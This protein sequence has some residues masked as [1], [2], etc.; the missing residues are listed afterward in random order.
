MKFKKSYLGLIIIILFIAGYFYTISLDGDIKPI[1][2]IGFVKF[3]NPD[4]YP[5]NPHSVDVAR[6]A[7][8]RNSKTVLVVHYGGSSNYSTY[9]EGNITIIQ[10]G[11]ISPK[12][13][14]TNIDWMEVFRFAFWGVPDGEWKFKANGKQFETLDEALIYIQGIAEKKGQEGSIPM[15]YHGTARGG[16]TLLSQGCGFPLYYY[17]SWK[18]Y[19][20]IAAYYYVLQGMIFPFF[21][22]PT[23]KY[24]LEHASELE[25]KYRN[26]QLDMSQKD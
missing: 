1:G 19:G 24:E 10:L 25:E 13:A 22:L 17:I 14:T 23:W 9:K 11:F 12:G 26:G 8:E 7:E 6:Y 20:R 4:M 15:F 21:N 18:K 5:G 16:N 2:R 3:S